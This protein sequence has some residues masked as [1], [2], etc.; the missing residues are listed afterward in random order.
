MIA[1]RCR[2]FLVHN[3]RLYVDT[4]AVRPGVGAAADG[5]FGLGH[6]V[7]FAAADAGLQLQLRSAAAGGQRADPLGRAAVFQGH[8]VA[9]AV[10]VCTDGPA[11]EWKRPVSKTA[12]IVAADDQRIYLGG[13]EL[14]AYSL[15]TQELLWA[16]QLPRTAAWS[17]PL[18]TK[19]RLYQ[20]T[21]RGICAID[22]QSGEVVQIFRGADL[23][24]LGGSLFVTPQALVTVSNLGITAYPRDATASGGRAIRMERTKNA[25]VSK[26]C[27]TVE[28]RTTITRDEEPCHEVTIRLRYH[29]GVRVGRL[30]RAPGASAQITY[31]PGARST[32]GIAVYGTGELSA[33]P[34]MVEIDLHVSGKAELTGDALVKYRDSKKR[35]LEALE[36]WGSRVSRRTSWP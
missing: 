15:K 36:N 12:V 22:K 27:S 17:L 25:R 34:N 24:S 1:F 7:R 3:D 31:M 8:A 5:Q 18:V 26:S 32:D 2:T 4:H 33:R 29:V 16:T 19:T 13:E 30:A 23:D 35:V 10:G 21:S 9:A 6:S 14:T 28:R 11:L 20:F